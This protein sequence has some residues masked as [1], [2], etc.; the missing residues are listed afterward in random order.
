MDSL[1]EKNVESHHQSSYAP[2]AE[3]EVTVGWKAQLQYLRH[4]FTSR[5]GWIG[6]YVSYG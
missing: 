3:A 6:N 5:D 2:S 1:D 4:Y